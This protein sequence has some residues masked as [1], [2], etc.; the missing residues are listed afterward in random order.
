MKSGF[1]VSATTGVEFTAKAQA[2]LPA[3]IPACSL[4]FDDILNPK[5]TETPNETLYLKQAGTKLKDE[6]YY[7]EIILN[8]NLATQEVVI[9]KNVRL[10]PNPT[11]DILNID[12]NGKRFKTVEV[13]SIDGKKILTQEVSSM[14]NVEVN[15]LRY[16]PGIY[17]VTLID[18]NGKT[19]PNKVIKK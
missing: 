2:P 6:P 11:K 14:N 19:Y 1:S 10:Y 4:T 16:P 12:F 9:D 18:S 8:G 17:M 5:L 3:D 15:L 13:Y 7:D